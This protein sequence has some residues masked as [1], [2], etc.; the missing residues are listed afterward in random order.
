MNI[1]RSDFNVIPVRQ[2]FDSNNQSFSADFRVE[3]DQIVDDGYIVMQVRSIG[4]P[5][6]H[7]IFLNNEE[8]EGHFDFKPAPGG[9]HAWVSWMTTFKPDK[10]KPGINRIRIKRE[11]SDNFEVGDMVVN[12]RERN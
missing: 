8:I 9:S 5:G 12:W 7:K 11:G 6:R 10:L 3:G 4:E 2:N 1:T